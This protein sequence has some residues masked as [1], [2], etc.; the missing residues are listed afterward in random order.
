MV[1]LP[2]YLIFPRRASTSRCSAS[3]SARMSTPL[4]EL[5]PCG[6]WS[7]GR[8]ALSPLVLLGSMLLLE[9]LPLCLLGGGGGGGPR[10][11][12]AP[13]RDVRGGTSL[14][15]RLLMP[16]TLLTLGGRC[17][18]DEL[19]AGGGAGGRGEVTLP[20]LGLLPAGVASDAAAALSESDS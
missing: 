1:A 19:R 3:R 7:C 4:P 12:G 5:P 14:E 10:C 8:D 17:R 9:L 11:G 16:S 2:I 18:T 20:A 15:M 6:C 13:S